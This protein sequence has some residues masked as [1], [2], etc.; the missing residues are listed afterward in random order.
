M[1]KSP[2][3]HSSSGMPSIICSEPIRPKRR[4]P[5][6]D[7]FMKSRPDDATLITIR[8]RYGPGSILRLSDDPATRSFAKPLTEAMVVAAQRY[9]TRPDRIARFIEELTKTPEEQNYAVRHLREA[10]PEAVPFLIEALARPGLSAQDHRLLVAN[11]GRLDRSAVPPLVA[12][13]DSPD[14]ALAADA[15]TVLGMIGDIQAVPHLTFPA[16][17]PATREPVRSSVPGGDCPADRA[18]VRRTAPLANSGLDRRCLEL[19]PPQGRVSRR[20]CCA[21]GPGIKA[22]R[23]RYRGRFRSPRPRQIFG[24]RFAREALELGPDDRAAQVAQLSLTLEK[25]IERVGFTSFPAPAIRPLSLRRS[26]ADHRS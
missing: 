5:Y 14:P 17:F 24:L 4:L 7:Q 12:A 1:P 23:S 9:A 8:D 25:A 10:G 18:A 21:S 3:L 15:A 13:L 2:K 19:S 26:P 11:I 22:V 16:A 20:S 6:V